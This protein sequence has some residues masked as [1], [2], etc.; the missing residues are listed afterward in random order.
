MPRLQLLPPAP[1]SLQVFARAGCALLLERQQQNFPKE[2]FKVKMWVLSFYNHFF[3]L[4]IVNMW[5]Q[6]RTAVRP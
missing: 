2:L 3:L 4:F 1:Q 6:V 5:A